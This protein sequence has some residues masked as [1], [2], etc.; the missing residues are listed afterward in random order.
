MTQ[1][2]QVLS[3][4]KNNDMVPSNWFVESGIYRYGARIYE[5][6]RDGWDIGWFFKGKSKT[7]VYFLKASRA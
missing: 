7:A 4:L 2:E 3:M 5:L 1:K 6:R